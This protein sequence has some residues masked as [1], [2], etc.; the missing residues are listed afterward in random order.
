MIELAFSLT[1]VLALSEEDMSP[2]SVIQVVPL[3]CCHFVH[4]RPPPF[5]LLLVAHCGIWSP[6]LASTDAI[7][8]AQCTHKHLPERAGA[9]AFLRA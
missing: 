9:V 2:H 8:L 4:L 5:L 7:M 1:I 6:G 3:P